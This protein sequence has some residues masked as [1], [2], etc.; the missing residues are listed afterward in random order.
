MKLNSNLKLQGL[1]SEIIMGT[2]G[3]FWVILMNIKDSS[4]IC[5]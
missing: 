1:K 5:I 4:R 2:F 3:L